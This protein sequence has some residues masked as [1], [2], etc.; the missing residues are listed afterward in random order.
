M[1]G[2]DWTSKVKFGIKKWCRFGVKSSY[3]TLQQSYTMIDKVTYF[4]RYVTHTPNVLNDKGPNLRGTEYI[5]YQTPLRKK[6]GNYIETFGYFPVN[7]PFH[8]LLAC[9]L[10]PLSHFTLFWVSLIYSISEHCIYPLHT[11]NNSLSKIFLKAHTFKM[12][13]L[14]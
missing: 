7:S 3:I 6:L 9:T 12:T 4:N 8:N 14:K 1:K 11:I 5:Q 13:S 2:R 10:Y